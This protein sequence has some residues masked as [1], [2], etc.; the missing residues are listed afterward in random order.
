VARQRVCPIG[1][2]LGPDREDQY[3]EYK[4]TVRWD[5]KAA[6]KTGVPEDMVVKTIA[7]FSNSEHGGTLL[8]GVADDGS[9]HGLEDDYAT[10]SKRGERGD[11]DLIGQHLQNVLI[12]RLGHAAM[13]LVQWEF[14]RIDGDDV[15]RVHVEPSGSPVYEKKGDQSIFWWRFPTGT[16]AI[17]DETERALVLG[18][19]WS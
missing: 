7:G 15:C 13:S 2:L 8:I 18:R 19:R 9:L 6:G 10:F 12:Q 14:H 17:K 3:L 4:S 11:R 16:A 5:I 1:E